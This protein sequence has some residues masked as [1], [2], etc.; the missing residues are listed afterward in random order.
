MLN[1]KLWPFLN[2]RMVRQRIYVPS[3]MI[4]ITFLS[5]FVIFYVAESIDQP[6]SDTKYE[7]EHQETCCSS[8]FLIFIKLKPRINTN[9]HRYFRFV[10]LDRVHLR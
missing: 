1:L 6:K 3:I 4:N 7:N 2:D 10:S 8:E 5:G 9:L